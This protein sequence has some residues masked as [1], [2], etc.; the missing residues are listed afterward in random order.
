M[1]ISPE[2][3]KSLKFIFNAKKLNVTLSLAEAGI[4][5]LANIFVVETKGIKGISFPQNENN[6]DNQQK[7][8]N[9]YFVTTG[10][11]R[12][13]ILINDEESIDTL[14][15]TYLKRINRE[16]LYNNNKSI[17]FLFNSLKL[18]YGEQTKISQFFKNAPNPKV[19]VNDINP[20]IGA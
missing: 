13:N 1:G 20:L 3:C 18:K 17:C 11:V 4:S 19:V 5:N 2:D 12:T 14:L 6:N 16:D 8:I 9:V 7:K 10:G 15:R